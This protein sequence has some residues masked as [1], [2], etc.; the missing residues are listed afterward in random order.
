MKIEKIKPL[1]PIE[2]FRVGT[3]NISLFESRNDPEIIEFYLSEERF[4]FVFFMFGIAKDVLA[5]SGQTYEQIILNNAPKSIDYYIKKFGGNILE[6]P[7]AE[8]KKEN[9]E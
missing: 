8:D 4:A 9:K 1:K 2:S 5:Q 7:F 6:N 3:F